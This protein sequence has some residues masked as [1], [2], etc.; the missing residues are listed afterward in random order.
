MAKGRKMDKEEK[1]EELSEK[2]IKYWRLY[3]KA[4]NDIYELDEN[5][6]QKLDEWLEER[7]GF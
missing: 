3:L 2:A 1:I 6:G 7:G 5:E 4:R